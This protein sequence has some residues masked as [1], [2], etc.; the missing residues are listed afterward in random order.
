V[1]R[2][3]RPAAP[4]AEERLRTYR[5]SGDRRIRN[6]VVAE[7]RWLA[8]SVARD[9]CRTSEPFD[10]LVQVAT[11][12]LIKAAERFD[13]DYGATYKSFAAVTARGEVRRYFRDAGWALRVPRRL[14]ELRYEVR[15]ATSTLEARLRRSPTTAEIASY[16]SVSIDEVIDTL[17]A[18]SNYRTRSLEDRPVHGATIGEGIGLLDPQYE[19]SDAANSFADLAGELGPRVHHLL[20]LRYVER[21]TQTEIASELGTSQVQVS[22]L[23]RSAH[24]HLRE[25]LAARSA[26]CD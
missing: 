7:H 10:D 19:A 23:L 6:E 12:G 15:A 21:M 4:S 22:R 1:P 11:V 16:L 3:L 5:A 17:C 24:R 9:L 14:Q 18:E 26:A 2:A 8:L 13:P 25:L 20:H